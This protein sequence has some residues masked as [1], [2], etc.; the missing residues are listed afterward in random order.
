MVDIA[1]LTDATRLNAFDDFEFRVGN[2]ND[3]DRWSTAPSPTGIILVPAGSRLSAAGGAVEPQPGTG[4]L[5]LEQLQPIAAEAIARWTSVETDPAIADALASAE[6]Q[7][8]DLSGATLGLESA[9]IIRI[10]EGAAG[11]GWF[12][13]ASGAVDDEFSTSV[14]ETEFQ[15]EPAGPAAERMD[16]LTVVTHELGHVLRLTD[17]GV[18]E[19]PHD[20][21][22]GSLPAGVRRVPGAD[23][24]SE[25]VQVSATARDS[26]FP[27][28]TDVLISGRA[29]SA[30][31]DN[32]ATRD[33]AN[34]TL[35][36]VPVDAL[37]ASGNFFSTVVFSLIGSPADMTVDPGTGLVEWQWDDP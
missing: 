6:F 33:I 1:G 28:G 11:Y 4:S 15:A 14:V 8:E 25:Q 20:L 12:I 3:P 13:D 21:M 29:S 9:G 7:I 34:V 30:R 17:L 19:H 24:P 18:V 5:T 36:G 10:D 16:L 27:A 35:N 32:P 22:T 23:R 31:I 26:Q 37:D 2:S